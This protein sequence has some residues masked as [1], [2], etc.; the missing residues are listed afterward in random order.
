M[1]FVDLQGA[2][3]RVYR[4]RRWPA[5]GEHPPIAGNYALL[6]LADHQIVALGISE[7]LAEA[8]DVLSGL[9]AGVDA[10]TRLNVARTHREAEHADLRAALPLSAS[11]AV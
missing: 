3:G 4:F 1:A 5:V 7:N 6:R 2:S 8:H 11:A 10:F 9:D